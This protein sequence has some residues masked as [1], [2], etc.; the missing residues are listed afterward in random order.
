MTDAVSIVVRALRDPAG[1]LAHGSNG[2]ADDLV[3]AASHHRVLL[4]LGWRLRAAGMLDEWPGRFV[5]AFQVA[6]RNAIA[7]DCVRQIEL[8]MVLAELHEAGVRALL[9]KGAA[10]AHTHYPAPHVRVRAD[11]DLLIGASEVNNLEAVIGRLGYGRPA[12]TSGRLVSYQS[13]YHKTDGYGVTHAFDVHWRISNLQSLANRFTHAELWE[14]RV[15]VRALGKPAVTVDAA[16]SLLLALVHRAGHHPNS[17]NLLWIYDL[18]VLGHELTAGQVRQVQEIAADR[19]LARLVADGLATA[20]DCFGDTSL[21]SV[22]EALRSRPPRPDDV[23]A[24]RESSTLASVLR[25]DL[26]A[27][28]TWRERA[29]LMREHLFPPAAYMRQRY[30]RWP[31]ALLPL[32]YVHRIARGAPAWLRR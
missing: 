30:P 1:S 13:H 26:E 8:A 15:P 20:R 4:L 16:S 12:E 7:V 17:Q 27:L 29:R 23:P 2:Y 18:H 11:T 10:V 31:V 24:I 5:H 28:P 21:E 9:F 6:E 32:A 14:G 25:L 22:I 3:A 19:G